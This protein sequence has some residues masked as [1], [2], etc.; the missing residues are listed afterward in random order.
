MFPQIP[1]TE[2]IKNRIISDVEG[3]IKQDVP[4]LPKAL[5]R[6][7]AG[8][9]SFFHTM[10]NKAIYWSYQQ[11]FP[12]MAEYEALVLKGK[13]VGIEAK[14]ATQCISDVRVNGVDGTVI[15]SGV[16]AKNQYNVIF[17]CTKGGVIAGGFTIAEFTAQ[18]FGDVGQ[19]NS[20]DEL[21]LITPNSGV[22]NLTVE[23]VK[24]DGSNAE[25]IEVLRNRIINRY[26]RRLNGGSY[27]DYEQWAY[28]MPNVVWVNP[29]SGS[30]PGEIYVFFEVNNQ[31][32]GIPTNDQLDIMKNYLQK[33]PETGRAD[34]APASDA[35]YPM[36]ISRK[37]F[38]FEITATNT[39]LEAKKEI[40]NAVKEYLSDLSPFNIAIMAIK[41]D[42]LTQNGAG[43]AAEI[44]ARNN[45]VVINSLSIKDELGQ[46]VISY[47]L[48]GGEKAKAGTFTWA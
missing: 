11:I 30:L 37:V 34:R 35:I 19:L 10:Q 40:E 7:I 18:D 48:I 43:S 33:N 20:G 16:L 26:Q 46:P 23:T 13:E 15:A 4:L 1:T 17:R 9:L 42:T 24:Q 36:K 21:K 39:T 2:E 38:N 14:K 25:S 29:L 27:A 8:G 41:N 5:I 31:P 44:A 47:Q 45:N 6:A 28:T 3:E 22:F 32:D 12:Q